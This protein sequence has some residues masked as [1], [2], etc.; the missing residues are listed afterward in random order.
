MTIY[1]DAVLFCAQLPAVGAVLGLDYGTKNVGMAVG[2][3]AV[4]L[5]LPQTSLPRA[6]FAKDMP[7]VQQFCV[8]RGVVALVVGLPL[9]LDGSFGASAQASRDFA[10][11]LATQL[12]IPALLWD[13]RLSTAAVERQLIALDMRRSKRA[14][15]IDSHAAAHILSGFFERRRYVASQ[16][17]CYSEDAHE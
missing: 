15:V 13:E 7:Q 8:Q 10:R 12:A 16:S 11:R 1:T 14:M 5:A 6:A 3:L 9:H 4:A 2:D 17:A